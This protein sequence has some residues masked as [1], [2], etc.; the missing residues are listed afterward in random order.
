MVSHPCHRHPPSTRLAQQDDLE[1]VGSENLNQTDILRCARVLARAET[2]D[3]DLLRF[4][5]MQRMGLD[6]E[7]LDGFTAKHGDQLQ[8]IR[9][10]IAG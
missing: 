9:Q 2:I 1:T 6:A 8:R 10:C 5:I 7:A 4:P 3:A